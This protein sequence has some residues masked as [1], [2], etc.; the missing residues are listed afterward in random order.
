[1]AIKKYN[2]GD[3]AEAILGATLVAK[4][5][6][7]SKNNKIEITRTHVDEV[8]DDLF[9]TGTFVEYSVKDI[10]TS[11]GKAVMDNIYFDVHVPIPAAQFLKKQGNRSIV[12][13]LY[14]SAISY[15]EDKWT[16][17]VMAIIGNGKVDHVNI[18]SDGVGAQT[19]TKADIKI[20]LNG[21]LYSR[22][23]SLKVSGGDQFAQISGDEFSKQEKLWKDILQLNISALKEEYEKSLSTVNRK[24]L[25]SSRDDQRL[26][27]LKETIKD[28]ARMVYKE[29]ARQIQKKIDAKDETM[30]HNIAM[31]VFKGAALEDE[32]IEL[33]KF[34]KSTYKGMSFSGADGKK[35]LDLYANALNR[36]KLICVLRPTGDPLVQIY[37]ETVSAN[38]LILK[39]RVKT[40]TTHS[41][42]MY[43]VYMR[44]L[45]EAGPRMFT[46]L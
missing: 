32:S 38:N 29:A 45:V 13:D 25:F 19:A 21:K 17:D 36:N 5:R 18:I 33:V 3:V 37:T 6:Q 10:S 20:S 12:A 28:A 2:R 7:A 27:A 4:F 40:E 34:G 1:M 35:F 39:I 11:R 9:N 46:V 43:T 44:N 24:E 41:G 8:L 31:L 14:Q 26:K 23:I 22:Q 42:A 15:V 16:K 30:Y